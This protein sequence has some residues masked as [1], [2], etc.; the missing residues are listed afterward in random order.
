MTEKACNTFEEI[1]TSVPKKQCFC[2]VL[3]KIFK[4]QYPGGIHVVTH[5]E[6]FNWPLWQTCLKIQYSPSH[7]SYTVPAEPSHAPLTDEDE[8]LLHRAC[9]HAVAL[10]KEVC[11]NTVS[12][13]ITIQ[14]LNILMGEHMKLLCKLCDAAPCIDLDKHSLIEAMQKHKSE[15]DRLT[16]EVWQLR[17]QLSNF[18]HQDIIEG[19][20]LCIQHCVI[21]MSSFFGHLKVFQIYYSD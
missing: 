19:T 9:S 3:G 1:Y 5:E 12:G 14:K 16:Q 10:L 13:K 11:N 15:Y 7:P 18:T 21:C 6:L 2:K 4:R 17:I 8:D 20:L